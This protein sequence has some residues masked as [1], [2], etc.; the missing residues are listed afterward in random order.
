MIFSRLFLL[1]GFGILCHF[2]PWISGHGYFVYPT[3]RNAYCANASCTTN[4]ALGRQGPLWGLP[5]NSTLD[6]ASSTT[7]TTCNGSVL[8]DPA[9]AGD[10]FDPGF[11]G[12]T[13][14][15]PAGSSQTFKIFISELHPR[16]NRTVY[17]TDGWQIRYR[18]GTQPNSIFSPINFTHVNVS[19]EASIGPVPASGF[20]LGQIILAT[21][22]VPSK[23]TSDGIFQFYWRNNQGRNGTMWLSCVDVTI[24]SRETINSHGNIVVSSKIYIV[25]AA[26]L[27]AVS[28]ALNT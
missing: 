23:P 18:D 24:T 28:V 17:P 13:A 5:A 26:L 20:Q 14:S 1:V 22:T 12:T 25:V 21:I 7:Q 27:I 8:L 19:R 3:A 11:K 2:V 4:G 16:E 15:W 10:T 9:S 6:E